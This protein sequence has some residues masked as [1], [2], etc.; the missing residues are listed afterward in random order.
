MLCD[1]AASTV[2]EEMVAVETL[3]ADLEC[4]LKNLDH[5]GFD[6]AAIFVDQALWSL[7]T[8]EEKCAST[9]QVIIDIDHAL[10]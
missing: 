8:P 6:Q 10:G 2:V 9:H 4:S 1:V 7:M 5:L 3:K